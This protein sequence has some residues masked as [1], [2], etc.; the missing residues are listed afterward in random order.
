MAPILAADWDVP[1]P[2]AEAARFATK[3]A[4]DQKE[5]ATALLEQEATRFG[6]SLD[7]FEHVALAYAYARAR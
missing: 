2:L 5:G 4:G 1:W 6:E 7:D 3:K